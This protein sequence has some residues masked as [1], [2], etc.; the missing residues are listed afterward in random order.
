VIEEG[1]ALYDLKPFMF[2]IIWV[3]DRGS[4]LKKALEKF[5]VVHCVAHRLNNILQKTFYQAETNKAKT[6]V[7]FGD[8]Y[9]AIDED[10]DD[11]ISEGGSEEDE[12]LRDDDDDKLIDKRTRTLNNTS[13]TT[14]RNNPTTTLAQLSSD[15]KRV[16]VTIIQ[17][18]DL[19]KYVKKVNSV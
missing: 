1:L 8:Y 5:Y 14:S 2:D 13:T 4:N 7:A 17:C 9:T 3:C 16:L 10:E 19:V 15:A 18:K 11:Q 12:A 6:E